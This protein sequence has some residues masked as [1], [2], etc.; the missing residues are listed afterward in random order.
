MLTINFFFFKHVSAGECVDSDDDVFN[1][2]AGSDSVDDDV[3]CYRSR[4]GE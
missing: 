1:Q 2:G 3:F 4:Q